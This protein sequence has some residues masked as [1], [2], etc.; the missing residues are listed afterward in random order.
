LNLRRNL[1]SGNTFGFRRGPAQQGP[2]IVELQPAKTAMVE[3]STAHPC[4]HV[5]EAMRH[6][7]DL[8]A[9]PK[10]GQTKGAAARTTAIGSQMKLIPLREMFPRPALPA[11]IDCQ[12]AQ[13]LQEIS[14]DS[15]EAAP[16]TFTAFSH[17]VIYT[18][19]AF[20]PSR[21]LTYDLCR[22]PT[23]LLMINPYA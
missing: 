7:I 20:T 1:G 15:F 6:A 18:L 14:V 12:V 8:V 4:H 9:L 16:S 10:L 5:H 19:N 3:T 17:S 21:V 22:M 11:L 13:S 23:R 2:P